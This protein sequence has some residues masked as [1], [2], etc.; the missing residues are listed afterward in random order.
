MCLA[1][2]CWA[3][4]SRC[5]APWNIFSTFW[6][7]HFRKVFGFELKKAYSYSPSDTIFEGLDLQH[8]L[9]EVQVYFRWQ[10]TGAVLVFFGIGMELGHCGTLFRIASVFFFG[11]LGE[12]TNMG[13]WALRILGIFRNILGWEFSSYTP[14]S[15]KTQNYPKKFLR[16]INFSFFHWFSKNVFPY[17]PL[18]RR[19]PPGARGE[20]AARGRPGGVHPTHR[21]IQSHQ[22]WSS[23]W[24]EGSHNDVSHS[25]CPL[26]L[27][28]SLSSII[29]SFF[30]LRSDSAPPRVKSKDITWGSTRVVCCTQGSSW[31]CSG[32]GALGVESRDMTWGLPHSGNLQWV[33]FFLS[34]RGDYRIQYFWNTP[35]VLK[36]T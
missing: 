18:P 32:V 28:R 23:L 4:L 5:I 7:P 19:R 22:A 33:N 27:Q 1:A 13:G 16:R 34:T 6:P 17:I 12:Q 11:L 26:F 8:I 2:H 31:E 9:G 10:E 15:N 29:S 21:R 3:P 20:S 24:C 35:H 25:S 36:G 30:P 14:K